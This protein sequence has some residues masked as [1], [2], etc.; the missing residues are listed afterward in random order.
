[1]SIRSAFLWSARENCFS[2]F[3]NPFGCLK[4]KVTF[5]HLM[6]INKGGVTSISNVKLSKYLSQTL[7]FFSWRIKL[8]YFIQTSFRSRKLQQV[9]CL[10]NVGCVD[11]R[12]T[13]E[14]HYNY[15]TTCS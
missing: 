3:T 11:N 6:S 14:K 12:V 4:L 9:Q 10:T 8:R 13:L 7:F 1:M 2:D 15:K 5:S